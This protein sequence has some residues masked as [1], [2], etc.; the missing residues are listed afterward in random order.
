MVQ[1][2]TVPTTDGDGTDGVST[3]V[4]AACSGNTN[5]KMKT[6]DDTPQSA[7]EV[8]QPCI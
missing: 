4:I 1:V 3:G 7:R 8:L 6:N 2:T 5:P